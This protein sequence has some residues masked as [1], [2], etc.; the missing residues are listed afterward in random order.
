MN[1]DGL[2]E[3]TLEKLIDRGFIKEYADLFHLENHRSEITEMEGFGEKSYQKLTGSIDA[4]RNTT[5]PRV[6]YGL[7]IANIGVANA[8]MLCRYFDYD[9]EKMKQADEESLSNIEGVGD[10]IASAFTDYMRNSQNLA[11]IDRLMQELSIQIPKVEE[12]SQTLEGMTFVITGSLNHYGSRNELKD[13]IEQKGGKVTGSVT[14]KTTCLI[15]NDNTS[16]STKN[17]KAKELQV[18]I[19]TE[20]EFLEQYM[21]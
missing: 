14:G 3:A 20:D 19:L 8:K 5:L 11:K 21:K 13:Q 4:A 9:L 6:I 18:P 7:G 17:K 10:V 16:T 1:I 12:G 15:N 2:S